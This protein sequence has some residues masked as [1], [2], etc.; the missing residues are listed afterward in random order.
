MKEYQ[1]MTHKKIVVGS[2]EWC[3]LP[4][5]SIP[6]IKTRVDSGAKTTALHAVNITPFEKNGNPWVRFE[7]HPIQ[8]D[9]KTTLICESPIVDKRRVKSSSGIGELRYVINSPITVGEN[10][11]EIEITLT[12]RDSMG[13][14]MLLGRQA[15]AGR[16]LVDPQ[17]SFQFG[18][19]SDEELDEHYHEFIKAP[20]G[21]HIA[22]LATNKNLYSNRRI[23][24]AA[25]ERGHFMDFLNIT[26]FSIELKNANATLK[27]KGEELSTKYDVIIPRIRP[28]LT[29]FGCAVVRHF[30]S[31]GTYTQNSAQAISQSRNSLLML[32]R[33]VASGILIPPTQLVPSKTD[34]IVNQAPMSGKQIRCFVINGLVKATMLKSRTKDQ[35]TKLTPIKIS[36][37]ERKMAGLAVKTL[38]LKVAGVDLIQNKEG[39]FV[40]NVFSSPSLNGIEAIT[41]TDLAEMMI[42]GIE[43]N[44]KYTSVK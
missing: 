43:K 7:V 6:A 42:I 11:W 5:L 35:E 15:M 2:E 41:A 27:Y 32:Q 40:Q 10:T 23:I 9:G 17:V 25:E 16:M 33:I 26:D 24:E 44:L 22:L 19:V 31:I 39:T 13:Y 21:L 30:G 34:S 12:N 37:E 8:Y 36:K 18:E 28:N 3:G 4:N 29:K 38:N 1:K 14:R 20:T